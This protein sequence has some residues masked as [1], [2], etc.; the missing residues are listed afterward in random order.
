M[1]EFL[2]AGAPLPSDQAARIH[3]EIEIEF[4]TSSPGVPPLH[5]RGVDGFIEGW[6]DWL[7]PFDRYELELRDFID[8]GDEI[9]V[10]AHVRAR[11]HR[12]GVLV[13]HD[14]AAV[15]T[16][17]DERVVRARFFLE[18]DAALAAAGVAD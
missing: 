11:T 4:A 6:S 12:D 5:Y 2:R 17:R 3:P 1:V 16:V 18:H 15:M 13:E 9:V 8:A 14:P 7:T 10:L